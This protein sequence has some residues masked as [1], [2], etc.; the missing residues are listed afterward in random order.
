M[1]GEFELEEK[2]VRALVRLLG[3]AA[4][5]DSPDKQRL[6]VMAGL[7][8]LVDADAWV[9]GVAPL[10]L[11]GQQPVY[12]FRHTHGFDETRMTRF[13]Q[14]VEHPDTGAMT[15]P[16]AVAMIEAQGRVTREL[17][18]IVPMERFNSSPARRFWE[19]A[20]IG[21]LVLSIGPV[22]EVGTSVVGFYRKLGSP[23]FTPRETRM[24]HILLTEMPW[25]HEVDM[26]HAAARPAQKLAPRQRLIVNQLVCGHSRKH[27]ATDLGLAENTVNGYVKQIYQHF[28][29]HS[30]AELVARFR[31]GDGKDG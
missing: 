24:M 25:L 2:D 26:P 8:E 28:G 19:A 10:L 29:V 21:P 5:I 14:A 20:D 1:S 15:A 11:P 31:R 9:W 13:L 27:I 6:H 4:A 18:R 22:P 3:E 7:R 16:L 30:Q 17:G 23:A 12:V